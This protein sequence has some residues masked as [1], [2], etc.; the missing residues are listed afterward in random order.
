M[1]KF[2]LGP[3]G[4]GKTKFLLDNIAEAVKNSS[5]CVVA[6]ERGQTMYYDID[7]SVRLIDI[8]EYD[9][10]NYD[11]FYGFLAGLMAGNYDITDIFID[12]TFK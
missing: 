7:H 1:I 3:K 4:S 5:G 9:I 8:D 11:S 2:I 12:A 10:S 6:V